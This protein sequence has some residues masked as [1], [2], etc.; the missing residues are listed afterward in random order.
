MT[1]LI[2]PRF[3]GHRDVDPTTCC[4][5]LL[6]AAAPMLLAIQLLGLDTD[7]DVTGPPELL[8]AL[9]TIA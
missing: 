2:F 4:P 1:T 5:L 7:F 8:D 3:D 6:G 9:D